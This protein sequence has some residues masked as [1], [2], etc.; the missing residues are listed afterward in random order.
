MTISSEARALPIVLQLQFP[1][2]PAEKKGLGQDYRSCTGWCIYAGIF[3]LLQGTAQQLQLGKS[4]LAWFLGMYLP[5]WF[6]CKSRL[7]GFLG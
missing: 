6:G 2:L 7:G 3:I 5:P 4:W 1:E